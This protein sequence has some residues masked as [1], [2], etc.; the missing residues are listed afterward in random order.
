MYNVMF[1]PTAS[2]N[3][4]SVDDVVTLDGFSSGPVVSPVLLFGPSSSI[5]VKF[6]LHE[7]HC[8][9]ELSELFTKVQKVQ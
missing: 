7:L 6:E 5:V 9:L 4:S 8:H 3:I 2:Q 1:S